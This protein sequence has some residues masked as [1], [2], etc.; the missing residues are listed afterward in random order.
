MGADNFVIAGAGARIGEASLVI[1]LA[2]GL[3]GLR[4]LLAGAGLLTGAG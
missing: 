4:G 2:M 1:V 3:N